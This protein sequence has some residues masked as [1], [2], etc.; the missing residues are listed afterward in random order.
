MN[1]LKYFKRVLF[2]SILVAIGARLYINFF[3]DGFIITFTAIILALSLYFNDDIHP[4]HLG[5]T[6]AVFSPTFRWTV[7]YI[8]GAKGY[9][10]FLQ[11]YPDVFFYITYGFV[12]YYF[13]SMLGDSYKTKFYY[14]VFLSDFLSNLVELIV[15][16]K[17]VGL[18]WTMIQGILLV[19][20]GRTILIM[21]FIYFA[22][23]YSTLLVRQEHEKRYQYLMML[24]SRFKSEIYFLHKNMNQIESVVGLSHALKRKVNDDI[25]LKTIALELS[26]SAHEIKK[27]Y[28]RVV[29][30][31]E[32]IYDSELN[33]K[34][35]NMK[36]LMSI[37]E[38]NTDDYLKSKNLKLTCRFKCKVDCVVNEH[39]YLMSILRNLINNSI[40]ALDPENG[41]VDVYVHYENDDICIY[42][43]D[44]GTGISKENEPFIFN[45]GFST[46]FD[47]NT[48]D[49]FRGM[50]LMLVKE[51]VEDVFGGD[52][53]FE[54]TFGEGTTFLVRLNQKGLKGDH[55]NE[56]LYT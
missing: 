21:L 40:D 36:D 19:A 41:V 38:V 32:E 51:M 25:E 29:R 47:Q 42:V 11:V 28:L 13:K 37:I 45:T 15:R 39:F 1:K 3:V 10:L 16:T 50:G 20:I 26:K 17:L 4:V 53:E 8:V 6:V 9:E 54:T 22:I 7:D 23:S 14:V 34:K 30:G 46:K 52:I 35:M 49:V 33:L 18:E 27:D 55:K 5:L 44:N 24:S 43:K 31:L 56:L 2:L 12:F 48:G